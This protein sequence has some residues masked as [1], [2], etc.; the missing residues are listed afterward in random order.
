MLMADGYTCRTVLPAAV[1]DVA[2]DG[3]KVRITPP[4]G[5]NP[6]I[7]DIIVRQ[8]LLACVEKDLQ[9][10]GAALV[11]VGHGTG[12][13]VRSGETVHATVARLRDSGLFGE[14][15]AGFLQQPPMIGDVLADLRA[16]ACVVVGYFADASG[17][18]RQDLPAQIRAKHREALYLGPIGVDPEV[19]D[20]VVELL[21]SGRDSPRSRLEVNLS[22]SRQ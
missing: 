8:A 7:G 22:D 13:D 3:A 6:R 1:A 15:R 5:S 10:A 16:K 2:P 14:V 17:H 18:A 19:A 21:S 12:R 9:P 20:V 11:V 4:L